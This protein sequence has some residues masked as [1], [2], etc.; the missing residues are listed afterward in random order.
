MKSYKGLWGKYLSKDNYDV[1]VR[2]A[3][4]RKSSKKHR[5]QSKY[6]KEHSDE[7]WEYFYKY[8]SNFKNAFHTPIEIYDGIQR[9]KRIIIVPTM[10]E[11]VVHHMIINVLKPI[12]MKGMYEHSYGSLPDR[13]GHKGKKA[14]EKWISNDVPNVKYCLKMDI[15]KYFDS[16]PHDILISKLSKLIK[17]EKFL[18][19]ILEI[20]SVQE[21]GIPLG[22][23]TSQWIANWYLQDLDHYIKEEL[24]AK[25]Y[26]RYMDDMVVLGSNKKKLHIIRYEV[27]KYLENN[28]GLQL[29]SNWQVFRF[30]YTKQGKHFGRDLDFMGFRFFRGRTIL[31]RRL[32][33][34]LVRKSRRIKKK[35]LK[36]VYDCK[37]MLAYLG[38]LDCTNTYK[39]YKTMVKPNINFQY[40]KRR[41]SHYDKRLNNEKLQITIN[42]TSSRC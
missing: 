39:M 16:I 14:I 1:A 13:G 29:K 19:V 24:H 4:R 30:D 9:K 28:L 35:P 20:I 15:R 18:S 8:A 33:Y 12:F 37:Q 42:E 2:N 31:R 40:C 10:N 7:E 25:H 36:S 41:V 22:F 26:I 32:A 38:W 27:E 5:K 17:D 23:Y 3:C 11:Q 34:K 21:Q 6:L